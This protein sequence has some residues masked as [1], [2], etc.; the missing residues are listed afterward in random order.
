M[1]LVYTGI[2]LSVVS[3]GVVVAG[4]VLTAHKRRQQALVPAGFLVMLVIGAAV[5]GAAIVMIPYGISLT[6][7]FV[8]FAHSRKRAEEKQMQ[9]E[10]KSTTACSVCP[11]RVENSV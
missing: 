6:D 2:A 11:V 1:S 3:L 9:H 4:G 8:F 10:T 5:L 7:D